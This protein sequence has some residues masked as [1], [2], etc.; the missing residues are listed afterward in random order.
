MAGV[1]RCHP[2]RF[3]RW[4]GMPRQACGA[5]GSRKGGVRPCGS[6]DDCRISLSPTRVPLTWFLPT[7]ALSACSMPL[8][9]SGVVRMCSTAVSLT[10]AG[11]FALFCVI[12][13]WFLMH[14]PWAWCM[15]MGHRLGAWAWAMGLMHGP[16]AW[17]MGLVR[18]PRCMGC[19]RTLGA[20][21]VGIRLHCKFCLGDYRNWKWRLGKSS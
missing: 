16:W 9:L 7:C 20:C 10:E 19:A 18:V 14:G 8:R 13:Y 11:L 5:Y 2:V 4:R 21:A 15:G 1:R 12:I 3:A 6:V 17:C